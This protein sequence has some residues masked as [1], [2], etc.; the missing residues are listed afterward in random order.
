MFLISKWNPTFSICLI[1]M[2][3]DE[4]LRILI[5]NIHLYC[6]NMLLNE[7]LDDF[8]KC[9]CKWSCKTWDPILLTLPSRIM[10]LEKLQKEK[11]DCMKWLFIFLCFM[12]LYTVVNNYVLRV[13]N[14]ITTTKK[15]YNTSVPSITQFNV[16]TATQSRKAWKKY[17]EIMAL[18]DNDREEFQPNFQ[19]NEAHT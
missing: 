3:L 19:S 18:S 11:G 17:Q 15:Y 6:W 5:Q 13:K 8:T 16:S 10:T 4:E 12:Y 9:P 2:E 14:N 7:F 1:K